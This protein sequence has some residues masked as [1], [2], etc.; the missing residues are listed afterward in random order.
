MPRVIEGVLGD[1]GGH[2]AVVVSRFNNFITSRL[3]DGALDTLRRHGVDIEE[4]VTICW[5]PGS[6][7]LPLVSRAL[8]RSG[9]Y[10]AVIALGCVIRGGTPHFDYVAAEVAKGIASVSLDTDIPI[11]FGVLTTDNVEQAVDRA[12]TKMGNKGTEAALSA[13]EMVHLM[14]AIKGE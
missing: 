13:L 11:T 6:F 2:F 4:R 9:E 10:D 7:E 14:R 1:P 8:A 3:L 12:G 5:A